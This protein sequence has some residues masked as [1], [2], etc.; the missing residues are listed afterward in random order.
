MLTCIVRRSGSEVRQRVHFAMG[1]T[2][3][4]SRRSRSSVSSIASRARRSISPIVAPGDASNV[5]RYS[6][7]TSAFA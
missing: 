4:S 2:K 5:E 3:A 6:F 1:S 7:T